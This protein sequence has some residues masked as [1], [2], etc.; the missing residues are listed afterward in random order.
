MRLPAVGS[1][2]GRAGLGP[3]M[4]APSN[5]HAEGGLTARRKRPRDASSMVI[6]RTAERKSHTPPHQRAGA[7]GVARGKNDRPGANFR[8]R[9]LS[10]PEFAMQCQASAVDRV[11]GPTHG[12]RNVRSCGRA[13]TGRRGWR[14]HPPPRM[15]EM[16]LPGAEGTATDP[17]GHVVIGILGMLGVTECPRVSPCSSSLR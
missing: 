10:I 11:C 2:G 15:L 16:Q 5:A 9:Q 6:G 3:L 12:S 13:G 7:S 1:A 14:V 8:Q 4:A 17:G